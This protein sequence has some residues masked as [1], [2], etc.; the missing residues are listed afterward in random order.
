MA[1]KKGGEMLSSFDECRYHGTMLL[2]TNPIVLIRDH[3]EPDS[4]LIDS[5]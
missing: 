1:V 5:P 3:L 4:P 2:V